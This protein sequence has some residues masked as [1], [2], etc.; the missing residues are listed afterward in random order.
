MATLSSSISAS[1]GTRSIPRLVAAVLRSV[2]I[3]PVCSSF[4]T[5]AVIISFETASGGSSNVVLSL[6]E[7]SAGRPSSAAPSDV[8]AV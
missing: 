5:S 6:A 1:A 2:F 7:T 4:G 8:T 3:S